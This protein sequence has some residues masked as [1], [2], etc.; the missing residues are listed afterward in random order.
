M[1]GMATH[2]SD[3]AD[4]GQTLLPAPESLLLAPPLFQNKTE[5]AVA[6]LTL[7]PVSVYPW[8]VLIVQNFPV[9]ILSIVWKSPE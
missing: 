9:H 3:N 6:I 7:T 2:I 5:Q 8:T 1:S 4:K